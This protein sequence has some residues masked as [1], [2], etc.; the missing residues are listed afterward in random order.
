MTILANFCFIKGSNEIDSKVIES[1]KQRFEIVSKELDAQLNIDDFIKDLEERISNRKV[2]LQRYEI[3]IPKLR[4]NIDQLS[5]IY[6]SMVC[7]T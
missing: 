4:Q 2:E 1:L 5:N 7:K 3:E 6:K